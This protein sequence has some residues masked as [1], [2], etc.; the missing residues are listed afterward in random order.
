MRFGRRGKGALPVE[1]PGMPLGKGG[2]MVHVHLR[3]TRSSKP[4]KPSHQ[5]VVFCLPK[6]AY[7]PPPPPPHPRSH[8]QSASSSSRHVHF[9]PA[10][11]SPS[12][13]LHRQPIPQRDPPAHPPY[14]SAG[15][16]IT[17]CAELGPHLQQRWAATAEARAS[18]NS[19]PAGLASYRRLV[20]RAES[21]QA[22]T[23]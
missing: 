16:L 15:R 6:H 17:L 18:L 1:F 4:S 10:A 3:K 21:F 7:Q 5:C 19:A 23:H 9:S 22:C 8:Q 11:L 2:I 20:R 12:I 13:Q 14:D